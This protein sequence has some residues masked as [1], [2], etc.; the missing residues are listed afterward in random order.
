MADASL[1]SRPHHRY[2]VCT[3]TD[4]DAVPVRRLSAVLAV[5]TLPVVVLV[6]PAGAAPLDQQQAGDAVSYTDTAHDAYRT[7]PTATGD[8]LPAPPDPQRSSAALDIRQVEWAPA[9]SSRPRHR[10]GYLTAMTVT[11]KASAE[12]SY[13]S[14]GQFVH[15]GQTCQLYHFLTPGIDAFANA[16][17]GSGPSRTF[18]GRVSGSAVLAEATHDGGTRLSAVFD[19]RLPAPLEDSGRTLN[20]LSAFTCVSGLEGLGCRPHEKQDTATSVLSYRL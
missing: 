11:G 3:S 12:A 15:G 18:V 20:L 17:C 4:G 5:L 13:V 16:F 9:P 10:G 2:D 19:S 1:V 8:P 14:Y 6:T 7:D